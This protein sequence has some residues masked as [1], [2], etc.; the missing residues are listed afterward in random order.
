MIKRHKFFRVFAV[1]LLAEALCLTIAVAQETSK[2]AELDYLGII[3][4][5]MQL[6]EVFSQKATEAL[7]KIVGPGRATVM[8]EIEPSLE[9]SKEQIEHWQAATREEGAGKTL[10]KVPKTPEFLPGIPMKQN[11]VEAQEK[12]APGKESGQRKIIESIVKYPSFIKSMRVTVLLDERV[13]EKMVSVCQT[14]VR[15]LLNVNEARGDTLILSTVKFSHPYVQ[16]GPPAWLQSPWL[17]IFLSAIVI[18]GMAALFLFGPVR[19]F[20]FGFLDTLREFRKPRPA[21]QGQPGAQITGS[22]AIGVSG[23]AGAMVTG[24]PGAGVG[25]IRATLGEGTGGMGA[26]V[27]EEEEEKEF[28]PLK[29]VSEEDLKGLFFLIRDEESATIATILNYLGPEKAAR[30]VAAFP[31]EKQAEIAVYAT[32]IKYTPKKTISTIDRAIRKKIDFIVGGLESFTQILDLM[33]D[34]PR[35]ALLKAVEE[36][37]ATLAGKLRRAILTFENISELDDQIVRIILSEVKTPELAVALRGADEKVMS[38]FTSNMAEAAQ[39]LLS[40]EME[41]GAP[42]TQAQILEKRREILRVIQRLATEGKID[43]GERRRWKL[44]DE[45]EISEEK[46]EKLLE[47]EPSDNVETPA[48]PDNERAFEHYNKGIE[49]YQAG[50][51]E[52]AVKEFEES[53]KYNNAV[54]QTYQYIGTCYYG[55]GREEEAVQAYRRAL[56]LNPENEDLRAWLQEHAA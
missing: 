53:L 20:L 25:R 32:R 49:L 21:Q 26:S 51:A 24:L 9:R 17:W 3:R 37:N 47:E 56:E 33:E 10:G 50:D 38:K 15:N 30:L 29:Y 35:E 13:S 55:L 2:E 34:E 42:A 27:E 41:Y 23:G 12:K 31:P 44:L 40:E 19:G 1:I 28:E 11:I 14:V 7:E 48:P 8:V 18:T 54:W 46:R 6:E 52:A 4:Q 43:L 5:K 39:K 36:K 45:S 22:G 16:H